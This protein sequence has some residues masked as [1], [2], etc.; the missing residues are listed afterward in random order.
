VE[1]R[2]NEEGP[3]MAVCSHFLSAPGVYAKMN[4]VALGNLPGR[5]HIKD[6]VYYAYNCDD[7]GEHKLDAAPHDRSDGRF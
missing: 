4:S 3:R 7:W 1:P 6:G 2:P 5:Y